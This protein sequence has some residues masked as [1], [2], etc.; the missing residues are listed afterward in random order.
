M[1]KSIKIKRFR[2]PVPLPGGVR[3]GLKRYFDGF[4]IKNK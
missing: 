2:N 4:V 1:I 3:G